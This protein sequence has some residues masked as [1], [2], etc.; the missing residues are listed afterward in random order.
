MVLKQLHF[1]LQMLKFRNLNHQNVAVHVAGNINIGIIFFFPIHLSYCIY[2]FRKKCCCCIT[3]WKCCGIV[4]GIT[5][6]I[7]GLLLGMA[8]WSF[9]KRYLVYYFFKNQVSENNSIF[10]RIQ[11]AAAKSKEMQKGASEWENRLSS[12]TVN[13]SDQDLITG[14]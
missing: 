3:S 2:I 10:F 14:K 12:D 9:H 1:Y 6:L 11:Q 7:I 4:T 8:A 5:L 13:L